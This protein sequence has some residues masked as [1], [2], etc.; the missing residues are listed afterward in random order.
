MHR[1]NISKGF[2]KGIYKGSI[3]T[4]WGTS[5]DHIGLRPEVRS[6]I[7]GSLYSKTKDPNGDFN[8]ISPT[9]KWTNKETEPDVKTVFTSLC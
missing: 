2:V 3:Y 9:N 1:G 7:L 6:S 8:G 4:I 5:K